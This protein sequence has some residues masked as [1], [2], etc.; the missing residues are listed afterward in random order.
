MVD[1]SIHYSFIK[2]N[3]SDSDIDGYGFDVRDT[4][5]FMNEL[6]LT[7]EIIYIK[8]IFVPKDKRG[9]GLGSKLISDFCYGYDDKIILVSSGA[10][11]KEYPEEPSEEIIKDTLRRLHR[12]YI[13]NGFV[14]TNDFIGCYQCKNS[15]L[16]NNEA[17]KPLLEY[18]RN[19]ENK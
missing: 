10:S 11:Q 4:L 17:A 3:A 16:F 18:F 6:S 7:N 14:D 8:S 13:K 12:F 19:G 15:Y 2:H 1:S 5:S 9:K